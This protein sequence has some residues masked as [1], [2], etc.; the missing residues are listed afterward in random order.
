MRS[1]SP[2]ITA[3]NVPQGLHV[4]KTFS[5]LKGVGCVVIPRLIRSTAQ[6]FFLACGTNYS[7]QICS[8]SLVRECR[9]RL[10][11][12]VRMPVS[13]EKCV[14]ILTFLSDASNRLRGAGLTYFASIYVR[15]AVYSLSSPKNSL[16]P[17][18]TSCNTLDEAWLGCCRRRISSRVAIEIVRGLQV[19]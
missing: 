8:K 6:W 7:E 13:P 14:N 16:K 10:H 12:E 9:L 1:F 17:V 15:Y 18:N 3:L 4:N 19:E 2:F 5:I 11:N